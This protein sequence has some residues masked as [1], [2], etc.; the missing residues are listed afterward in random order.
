MRPQDNGYR[1]D[2]R[3][4]AFLDAAG[5][6]VL[7]KGSVPLCVQALHYGREELE[8]Q[9]HRGKGTWGNGSKERFYAPLFPRKEVMLN[10]DVR[11]LGLGNGSCGPGPLASYVFPNRREAW[12]V[13]FVPVRGGTHAA[14]NA[15]AKAVPQE[16]P[17]EAPAP[18]RPASAAGMGFD[19]G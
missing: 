3:W 16:I 8:F 4:A 12:T 18:A 11:Q 7:V 5:D 19:G 2:V 6:G 15:A 10:L 9:R 13:T 14:L 1:T 17:D